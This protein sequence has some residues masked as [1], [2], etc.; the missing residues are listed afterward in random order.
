MS[1]ALL[2]DFAWSKPSPAAIKAAGY[3]GVLRY[4]SHDPSKDITTAEL[5]ALRGAGLSVGLVWETTA[6][7]AAGGIRQAVA[8]AAA[9]NTQ[10][11]ALGW[12][13]D[14]PIYYA[15]DFDAT[16]EQVTAYYAALTAAP[17]R[18]VGCYG[19]IRVVDAM[20]A[21]QHCVFGWQTVAWSAGEVSDHAHI[22]QRSAPTR[23]RITG[24]DAGSYDED[25]ALKDDWGQCP[26]PHAPALPWGSPPANLKNPV[27]WED[28]TD[29]ALAGWRE[30]SKVPGGTFH[31]FAPSGQR[32]AYEVNAG[33]RD[34]HVIPQTA[35]V[36]GWHWTSTGWAVRT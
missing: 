14:R 12:P 15:T 10:A 23:P 6:N 20:L 35:V 22:Y 27:R 4:L 18:P 1:G 36:I 24:T 30:A 13:K 31:V 5:T 21:A 2:I 3:T 11:D 8:D 9:A 32:L 19:G 33:W 29:G 26:A 28:P 17:G 16:P 25:V 7:A 34:P